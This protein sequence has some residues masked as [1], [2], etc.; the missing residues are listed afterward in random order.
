MEARSSRASGGA[1]NDRSTVS[2]RGR[3]PSCA[4]MTL[5]ELMVAFSYIFLCAVGFLKV[6][7][8][9]TTTTGAQREM[10]LASEAARQMVGAPGGGLRGRLRALQRR[11]VG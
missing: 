3:L 1:R 6:I 5:L 4:G 8:F 11:S 7:A 10:S 9:A 2:V